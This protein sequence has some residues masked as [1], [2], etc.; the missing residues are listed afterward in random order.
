MKENLRLWSFLCIQMNKRVKYLVFFVLG[1]LTALAGYFIGRLTFTQ[2]NSDVPGKAVVRSSEINEYRLGGYTYINP[3]LECDNYHPSP[4]NSVAQMQQKVISYINTA[5]EQNKATFISVYFRDLNFGPWMGIHESEKFSPANLLRVPIMIAALKKED[6]QPGF[7][8]QQVKYNSRIIK[9][10]DEPLS[11]SLIKPGAK[12][13]IEDLVNRMILNSDYEAKALLE[14]QLDAGFIM[15][16]MSD[17][18][19]NT[20]GNID[21]ILVSVR[22]YSGF[23][24][25]LYN[26]TYLSR[27]M[28]EKAL[29]ILSTNNYDKGIAAGIPR[30]T[31][32][33]HKFSESAVTGSGQKQLHECGI[34]Y[35]AGSPYLLCIMTRGNDNTQ[36]SG[37]ISDIS[38]LVYEEVTATKQ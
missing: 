10:V 19:V 37:I 17:I 31:Q 9:P 3:L 27:A 20:A 6:A 11:S 28:S 8:K 18:G 1:S 25:L 4:L 14:Q 16:V 24:R 35:L 12:Y 33:A 34:I 5:K 38:R 30:G 21:S 15:T 13:S 7:F 26:A 32:I 29:G 36:L 2:P 22:D 23:F